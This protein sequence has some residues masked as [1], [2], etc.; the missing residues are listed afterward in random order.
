M[1]PVLCPVLVGRE[2][3]A[4]RLLAAVAA[5]EAGQGR[6]ILLAGEAGIGKSR[7]AREIAAA[8]RERRFVVLTGRGVSG[9]V[10]TPFQP[11]S[12]ALTAGVRQAGALPDRAELDPFRPA[13][14]V[15]PCELCDRGVRQINS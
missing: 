6:T 14:P 7:L 9:G 4:R 13:P 3:Q 11:F 12:E 8:A 1:R 5:A 10:R 2:T 15:Q